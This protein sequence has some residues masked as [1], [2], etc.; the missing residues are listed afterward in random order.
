MTSKKSVLP[1]EPGYPWVSDKVK[2]S[3]YAVN[4]FKNSPI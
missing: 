4:G 3:D 1:G 2:Q